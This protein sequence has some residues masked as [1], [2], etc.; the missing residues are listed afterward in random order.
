MHTHC[1]AARFTAHNSVYL[2]MAES[3]SG[4]ETNLK[5]KNIGDIKH[6]WKYF[7]SLEPFRPGALKTGLLN[8][9]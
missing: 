9:K 5:N 1:I 3:P 7:Q 4:T 8:L 2:F 6:T